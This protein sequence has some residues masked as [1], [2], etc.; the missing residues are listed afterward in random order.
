VEET[1]QIGDLLVDKGFLQIEEPIEAGII[2]YKVH[3]A[4]M[5]SRNIPLDL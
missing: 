5:R 1:R 3:F 4:R 2:R